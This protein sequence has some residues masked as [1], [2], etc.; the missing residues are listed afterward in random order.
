MLVL[1]WHMTDRMPRDLNVTLGPDAVEVDAA[2][3]TA[4]SADGPWAVLADLYRPVAAAVADVADGHTPVT[5]L[6]GDCVTPLAVLAGLRRRQ[7]D[8]ALVWFDAHGDFH[9]EQT[10]TSGYLGG[11]P[12]A[13]AVGRGDLTLPAALGLAPLAEEDVVLVDARDLDPGEVAALEAS[14]VRHVPVD[15]LAGGEVRLPRKPVHLH[16]DLDVLDPAVL[17]G[18]RFP[19]AGGPPTAAVAAAVRAVVEARPLAALSIAATWRPDDADRRS[20]D[21]ALHAVLTAAGLT[22]PSSG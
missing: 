6:A 11:F 2:P 12:L 14:R 3:D 9:T 20:A 8:P 17:P 19:A 18:L 4:R 16:V 15:R 1:P 7:V 22:P 5:V 10:T 21:A 13:K